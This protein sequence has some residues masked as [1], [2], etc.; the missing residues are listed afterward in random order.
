VSVRGLDLFA[1]PGGWEEGALTLGHRL[2]G[3]ELVPVV[4]ATRRAAGHPTYEA[5]VAALTPHPHELDPE[6]LIGS[7]PCPAFSKAGNQEGLADQPHIYTC[8][9]EL[10]QLNVDGRGFHGA[11][12]THETSMLVVEPLRWALALRPAR[13]ALEQVE[14]VLPLWQLFAHL[15]G[16][17]GYA[18][19][20]GV[21]NA[22]DYGVPQ[23]RRRAFL[24]ASLDHQPQPPPP[25]HTS[26]PMTSL[27]DEEL[28]PWVTMAAALGWAEGD[29]VGFPRK[30]DASASIELGGEE[31][32]E[33]DLFPASGPAQ[34]LTE[35]ARSWQRWPY[36]RPATTIQGDPR[37]W[38]PGHKENS[39][40]PPGKY[41]QRRGDQAIRITHEEGAVLQ[42]FRRD[43]PWQGSSTERWQ[44]IGNAVPPPLAAAVLGAVL[45]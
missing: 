3:I 6:L 15:L 44:Q 26:Y 28:L 23:V 29:L 27:W 10:A 7:P 42:G 31:Y 21:L 32:R 13:V 2:L 34:T 11:Y 39:S 40:D 38:A 17:H 24:L 35:K 16:E 4:C 37:V 30:A 8:A 18:T 36:E 45:A 5:D 19:W 25:T 41:Q 33:R 20:V 1:G 43:Y 14:P 12:C 9:R 22:A